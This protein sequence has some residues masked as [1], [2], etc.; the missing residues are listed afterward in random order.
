MMHCTCPDWPVQSKIIDG[1]IVFQSV[2]AGKDLYQE[3]G[4]KPFKFCPWCGRQLWDTN[5]GDAAIS[6]TKTEG[7]SENQILAM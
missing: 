6:Q 1:F 3:R 4:G 2:R 5:P 7:G